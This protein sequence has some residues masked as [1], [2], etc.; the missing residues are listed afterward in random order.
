MP[1]VPTIAEAGVTGHEA[2]V[3]LGLL[4]PAGAP[5]DI[6]ARLNGE[7]ARILKLPEVRQ[8]LASTGVEPTPTTPEEFGAFLRAEYDK[9]G[10][11][12]RE[13]GATVN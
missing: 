2:T 12:V 1:E 3:W 8:N 9:W 10:R 5:R 7:I 6:V 13:T 11:V 4:A